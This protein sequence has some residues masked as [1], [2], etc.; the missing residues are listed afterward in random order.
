MCNQSFQTILNVYKPRYFQGILNDLGIN[1]IGDVITILKHAIYLTEKSNND[2]QNARYP[3]KK[4]NSE[5]KAPSNVKKEEGKKVEATKEDRK[6]VNKRSDGVA[7]VP[8]LYN[9]KY[10]Q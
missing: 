9:F 7:T 2:K 1:I 6:K 4:L 5:K 3:S 10:L 8:G